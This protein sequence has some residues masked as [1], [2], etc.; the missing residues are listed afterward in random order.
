MKWRVCSQGQTY[1]SGNC[2]VVYFDPASGRT[3]LINE[4][5]DWLLAEL[6]A[7]PLTT[8]QILSRFMSHSKGITSS[9]AE[10]LVKDQIRTLQSFDLI[11]A[12]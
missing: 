10:K 12:Y 7:N 3:H 6:A 1:D 9:E 11:E 8:E 4:V 2:S 5:A